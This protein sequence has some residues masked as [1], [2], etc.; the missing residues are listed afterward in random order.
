MTDTQHTAGAQDTSA[1]QAPSNWQTA[2]TRDELL[3]Q[4]DEPTHAM[5]DASPDAPP[6]VTPV[7]LSAI[8]SVLKSMLDIAQ[9]NHQMHVQQLNSAVD[10]LAFER[11]IT[12]VETSHETLQRTEA[13]YIDF[14]RATRGVRQAMIHEARGQRQQAATQYEQASQDIQSS[15]KYFPGFVSAI[16]ASR[17]GQAAA[18]A[19]MQTRGLGD[20]A[21]KAAHDFLYGLGHFAGRMTAFATRLSRQA[22]LA[23]DEKITSSRD[24][25]RQAVQAC[26]KLLG[27]AVERANVAAWHLVAES[28]SLM[29][30]VE[31]R[32][33]RIGNAAGA[34]IKA[35][36]AT[37]RGAGQ[38]ISSSY[39]KHLQ[40]AQ[41]EQRVEPVGDFQ[42][43]EQDLAQDDRSLDGH[44]MRL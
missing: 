40:A 37:L 21:G 11:A 12:D 14:L 36:V 3:L 9:R 5:G 20:S 31:Q 32:L 26:S 41:T 13:A 44:R 18:E 17:F 24:S 34:H 27:N 25:I 8:D 16:R 29:D 6:K 2:S 33:T 35:S 4:A 38:A 10:D 22:K 15:S 23:A 42:E 7:D 30:A 19:Y 28:T 39:G 1:S 43:P